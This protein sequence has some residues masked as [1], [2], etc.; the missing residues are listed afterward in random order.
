MIYTSKISKKNFVTN[1]FGKTIIKKNKDIIK[2]LANAIL[3][4][5]LRKMVALNMIS[6]IKTRDV[7]VKKYSTTNYGNYYLVVNNIINVSKE[8]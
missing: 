2:L 1:L 3:D 7:I 8:I 6:L 4:K 5:F